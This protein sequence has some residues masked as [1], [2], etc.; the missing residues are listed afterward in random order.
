MNASDSPIVVPPAAPSALRRR[1]TLLA[2]IAFVGP[3]FWYLARKNLLSASVLTDAAARPGP[4]TVG[5]I[6]LVLSFG[7]GAI[8]VGFLLKAQGY[9]LSL[10]DVFR[11]QVV[12][13]FFNVALPGAVSGDLVKSYYLRDHSGFG[14]AHA[15]GVLVFDRVVG[16]SAMILTSAVALNSPLV[17]TDS[18][19]AL[20]LR[21]AFTLL[22]IGVIGFFAYLFIVTEARDPLLSLFSFAESKVSF[23]GKIRKLY[24][25]LKSFHSHR[26][27]VLFSL[28]LSLVIQSLLGYACFEF[29]RAIGENQIHQSMVY[30]VVPI[31]LI[32]T[33]VPILPGGVGTGH[34]AFSY[35]FNWMGS[36]RG[37]DIFSLF[38]LFNI[39]VG[40]LCGV[41]YL[42]FKRHPTKP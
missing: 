22:A 34:A 2:K 25:G 40:L 6:A 19:G 35:L 7:I 17:P 1:L 13:Q 36:T 14:G 23:F 37:A 3:V 20:L 28:V 8:R 11:L 41:Y 24:V 42:T 15:L 32:V 29:A 12:G 31:G 21:N 33:A 5:M 16:L 38:A 27:A 18:G 30:A 10:L 26:G 4:L 39:V 9:T